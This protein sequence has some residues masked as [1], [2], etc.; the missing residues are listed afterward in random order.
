MYRKNTIDLVQRMI[1]LRHEKPS[2]CG[3][4]NTNF[5]TT[6]M[7]QEV[8]HSDDLVCMFSDKDATYPL[9][10]AFLIKKKYVRVLYISFI[11]SLYP[12][13]GYGSLLTSHLKYSNSYQHTHLMVRSTTNALNFY[14]KQNFGVFNY[15]SLLMSRY[16]L[17]SVDA[18]LTLEINLNPSHVLKELQIRGWIPSSSNEF[19]LICA[20][21]VENMVA[22]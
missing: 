20:R 10:F 21:H 16:F 2:N 3:G 17:A 15:S 4:I 11:V 5:S 1:D 13:K 12:C 6:F 8:L 7:K 19:P 9:S 22:I 14:T 18:P